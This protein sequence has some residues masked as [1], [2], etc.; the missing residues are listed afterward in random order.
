[1]SRLLHNLLHFGRLLRRLGIDVQAVRMLDVAEALAFIDIGRRQDFYHALRAL[2]IRRVEDLP[3]FDAAFRAFWRARGRGTSQL[4]LRALGEDLKFGEPEVDLAS[5]A[6]ESPGAAEEPRADVLERVSLRTYSARETLAQRDFAALTG[7]ELEQARKLMAELEWTPGRRRSRRWRPGPGPSLDMRRMLRAGLRHGGEFRDLPMRERKQRQRPL[8]L[9]CDVSGSMERYARMLL[10]FV[11]CL[12][13][14][15][16]RVEVFLFATRLTRITRELR[17]GQV[18][19]ALARLAARTPDFSGGTRIGESLRAFHLR[20]ARRTLGRGPVVLLI[21]DGWDRG[22]PGM[23]RREIARLQ[24]SCYRL[25][26]L[27][28]LLGS[29]AYEPLTRG[30]QAALPFVD[31]FL[32]VH[33]LRSL[34]HL[35]E[36]LNTLPSHRRGRRAMLDPL[37]WRSSRR[38]AVQ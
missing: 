27:N 8:V 30:M 17:Q 13:G 36:H 28:P 21:S 37:D 7:E 6:V 15:L 35:A 29:S 32:P 9:F 16:D 24:R 33:N 3:L 19:E 18:N 25:I 20:W 34:E 5:L 4:D 26:W 10:H 11:H 12:A 22:E 14:G 1:M 23:L 31:D 2:L 38:P